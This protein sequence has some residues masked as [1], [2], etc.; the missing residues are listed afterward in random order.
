MTTN[1]QELGKKLQDLAARSLQEQVQSAQRYN[2]LI[3][4]FGSG[5]LFKQPA[6]TAYLRFV[7]EETVRYVGNLASLSLS[8]SKELFEL[9]QTYNEKFF[10][11]VVGSTPS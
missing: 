4:K 11:Q 9:G 1:L 3:Q 7:G 5:E 8:Y 2:E 6:G 10:E